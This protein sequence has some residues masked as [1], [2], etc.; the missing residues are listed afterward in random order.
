MTQVQT[1]TIPLEPFGKAR[2][3]VTAEKVRQMRSEY[4]AGGISYSRLARK[5]GLSLGN[6]YRIV[7]HQGWKHV[8]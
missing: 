4:A 8:E 7:N 1:A 6:T 5:Y 3:R 2:P